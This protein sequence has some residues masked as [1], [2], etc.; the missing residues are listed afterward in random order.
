MKIQTWINKNCKSLSGK[1]ICI[2]G[3]TGG[4]AIQFTKQLASLGANF[5]FANRDKE[6][7]EKQKQS[8]TREFPNI[9]IDI[10]IDDLFDINSVKLFVCKLKQIH[11]DILILNS[12]VYN[13]SR[14]TSN[15]GFDN[16]FQ[17]NFISP[18][19]IAKQMIPSL[20]KTKDSKVIMLSSI[21]HNYS[22]I[23]FNDPQKQKTQKCNIIYGNSKRFLTF[24][25]QKLLS[26][27]H[28]DFAIVHPGVTLTKM[29][30]HYP[31]AINW[32]VKLGI[33]AFFPNP[34]K[35]CLSVLYGVFNSTHKN[36]W[37]GPSKFN[38]WGFPK[39]QKLNTCS[40]IE[41]K[42]IFELAE[43]FYNKIST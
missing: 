36:E 41:Q 17:I 42:Q 34:D 11:V 20:R 23:D 24:S 38:I 10:M 37:I 25:L 26:D 1:T 21:A 14:Q 29:T 4:L 30:S 15:A 3:S 28:V 33:K 7:S 13:V 18:Y 27:S 43:C 39:K 16:V 35:A 2:T 12:A 32:L 31:K 9:K 8:L 6:K 40:E 19:F 22:K 5:I